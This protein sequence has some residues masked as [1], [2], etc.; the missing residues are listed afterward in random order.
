MD[1]IYQKIIE[2]FPHITVYENLP[3]YL[4]YRLF[5]FGTMKDDI[6]IVIMKRIENVIIN[7]INTYNTTN[8]IFIELDDKDTYILITVYMFDIDMSD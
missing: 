1:E 2:L 4:T 6:Y 8:S 7:T 3:K 5:H